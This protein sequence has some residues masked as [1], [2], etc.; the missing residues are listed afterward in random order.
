GRRFRGVG[1]G[2]GRNLASR[3]RFCE[4]CSSA[5]QLPWESLNPKQGS[6]LRRTER[7]HEV[8]AGIGRSFEREPDLMSHFTRR[9]FLG[10]GIPATGLLALLGGTGRPAAAAGADPA[11]MIGKAVNYLRPRQGRDG[12]WS[13]DREPG[14]TALVVTALLRLGRVAPDE[15]A[16]T[17]GL[18]FLERYIGPKG[19]VSEAP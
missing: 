2:S 7:G 10:R 18:A 16:V 12:S 5:R 4:R 9:T 14:I 17:R 1:A 8:P 13:G 6:A 3:K 11:E 19:G 15:P